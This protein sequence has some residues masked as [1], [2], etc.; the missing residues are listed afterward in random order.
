MVWDV[1]LGQ[2]TWNTRYALHLQF[3]R[4]IFKGTIWKE[5]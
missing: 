1:I 3:F 2:S 5:F 4:H